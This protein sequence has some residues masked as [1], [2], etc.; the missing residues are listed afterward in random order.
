M[1]HGQPEAGQLA[2]PTPDPANGQS[3]VSAF[4][5]SPITIAS[6]IGSTSA[7]STI[8]VCTKALRSSPPVTPTPYSKSS[9]VPYPHP[10][11]HPSPYPKTR[12]S[13]GRRKPMPVIYLPA[14]SLP[15]II[16]AARRSSSHA[17][18][19]L[20]E[21]IRFGTG[22]EYDRAS[23]VMLESRYIHHRGLYRSGPV[24]A[25]SDIPGQDAAYLTLGENDNTRTQVQVEPALDLPDGFKSE[26]AV[27]GKYLSPQAVAR[28]ATLASL[29]RL[30]RET[31]MAIDADRFNRLS[32]VEDAER[33]SSM[34]EMMSASGTS[35]H[36]SGTGSSTPMGPGRE[37]GTS[38]VTE[39]SVSEHPTPKA[40]LRT[41]PADAAGAWWSH[42]KSTQ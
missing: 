37:R 36:T 4:T 32:T 3:L 8:P 33:E 30:R 31:G 27:S 42:S 10:Q 11:H 19:S 28:E 20:N 29:A 1:Q 25:S 26:R 22:I 6:S 13:S 15:S 39:V 40:M 23:P 12:A 7:S 34:S 5:L 17:V 41:F 38:F 2:Q 18:K 24:L 21:E 35:R 9:A 14:D 16:R